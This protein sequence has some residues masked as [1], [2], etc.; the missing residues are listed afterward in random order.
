MMCDITGCNTEL[1]K[2][3]AVKSRTDGVMLVMNNTK[4]FLIC[5]KCGEELGFIKKDK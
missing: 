3:D 1:D 5:N 2:F 4:A